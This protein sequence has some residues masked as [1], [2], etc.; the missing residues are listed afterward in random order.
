MMAGVLDSGG[1]AVGHH[2]DFEFKISD[3]GKRLTMGSTNPIAAYHQKG[4]G[5]LPARPLFVM[6]KKL[7]E[8]MAQIITTEALPTLTRRRGGSVFR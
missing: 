1:S 6:T 8:E 3:K 4:G 7:S 5:S 2:P